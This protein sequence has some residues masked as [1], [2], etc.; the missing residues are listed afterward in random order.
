MAEHYVIHGVLNVFVGARI[1]SFL[2][3]KK[4]Y[5]SSCSSETISLHHSFTPSLS[6]THFE[7]GGDSHMGMGEGRSSENL[8][9]TPKED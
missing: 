7:P 8:N 4:I 5:F 3:G 1:F 9:L 6:V 2:N